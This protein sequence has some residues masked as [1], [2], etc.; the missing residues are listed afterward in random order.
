VTF[1]LP[2]NDKEH[3]PPVTANRKEN[4]DLGNTLVLPSQSLSPENINTTFYTYRAQ[5]TFGLPQSS[6]GV[7]VAKYF[8]R[9]IFSSC[10]SIDQFSLLPYDDEKGQ[11]IVS[12]DQVPEDNAEFY[13][14]YYHNHRVLAHGNLTGMVVYQS[15]SPWSKLKSPNHP[16]FNWLRLNKVFLNQIKFK[17]LSLV[18]CGFLLGAHPGHLRRDEA[19]D[20]LRVS[21]G[22]SSDEESPFQLSSRSVSVPIQEGKPERYAFQAV[23]IE[24]ST[25]YA[26]SLW[27]K[28]FS[29]ANP[30]QAVKEYPYTGQYQFIPFLKTKEW[31]VDKILRLAKLHVKIVQDL[32]PIFLANLR[33]IHNCVN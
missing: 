27:E 21:L 2:A 24:T 33:N 4:G 7:N 1:S 16:F 18:P 6:E 15:S 22:F 11:Q 29:L 10:E 20:E 19:E 13:S 25:Q 31:T 8:R 14:T 28:F 17:A 12:L 5:L 3:T 9:W 32:R 23:V 26:A 30:T